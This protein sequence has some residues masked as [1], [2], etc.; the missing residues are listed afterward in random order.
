VSGTEPNSVPHAAPVERPARWRIAGAIALLCLIWGTTWSV[1]QIG[2]R[3][4]PPFTGVAVRFAIAGGLL[5]GLAI[6]R[7][8]RLGATRR[9]RRLWLANGM[10]SFAVSY[11]VVYWAEQWVPSGL[12]AILFAVYPLIVAILAHFA[13]SGEALSAREICGILIGFGGVGVIFSEDLAA[14]GGPEVAVGAMVMLL[15]P[16]AAAGGT[17]AVKKWGDNIHPLSIASVPMLVAAAVI[18]V[19]A[20]GLERKL[21]FTWDTA[22]VSAL[23]YLAVV[24]SAVTFSLYFWLLS[25]LPA[26]RLA[27]IAYVI[28]VIAVAVG[29]L[30]D[31]PL[32]LRMI[33]GAACVVAGV[34]LARSD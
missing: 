2:L 5:L 9:E 26:K 22:S 7:G 20:V 23:L 18:A 3:G 10:L 21:T 8:I 32:T 6:A 11:G 27:L 31:E 13:L 29:V 24:G 28:P 19:P 33:A 14:L 25:H 4:I 34:V 17:V 12:A 15:S 1:I 16:L 30:R